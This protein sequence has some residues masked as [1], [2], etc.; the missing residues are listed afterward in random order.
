VALG[1]GHALAPGH[2]KAAA[3]AYLAGERG[4]PRDAVVLGAVV[5][6]VH[7]ASALTLGLVFAGLERTPAFLGVAT[8]LLGLVGACLVVAVGVSL[9]ARGVRLLRAGLRGD[10]QAPGHT[11]LAPV[12]DTGRR[13]DQ[14]TRGT[15]GTGATR[16]TLLA[17]GAGL[18][19][20]PSAFLVISTA[21]FAGRA[22]YGVGLLAAFSLGVGATVAVVGLA[23]LHGRAVVER[24]A[25]SSS[26]LRW[27][28]S[29][30][31]L[32]GAAVVTVG[33]LVLAFGAAQRL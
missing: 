27:I 30:S 4:R 11:H 28:A 1:A 8:P 7:G 13:R 16:R 32:V 23:A 5:A 21:L 6:F 12:A 33:G 2:A 15:V 10:P 26:T 25:G 17:V 22:A 9:L 24:R 19:P 29:V 18:L 31:P 14:G 3:A 20:S